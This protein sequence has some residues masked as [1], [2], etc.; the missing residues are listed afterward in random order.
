MYSVIV[1]AIV[2]VIINATVNRMSFLGLFIMYNTFS[3]II[4]LN[5]K[6]LMK[7]N[8]IYFKITFKK[9]LFFNEN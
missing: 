4:Q 8:N 7:K 2:R 5:L 1:N 3:L 6:Q 9:L